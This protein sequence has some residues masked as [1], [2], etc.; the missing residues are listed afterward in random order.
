MHKPLSLAAMPCLALLNDILDISKIEAKRL[1]L[2]HLDF[3]LQNLLDDFISA[4]TLQACEK[5]LALKC[6]VTTEVPLILKGDPSRLRQILANLVSNAIKFT[7]KGEVLVR[8]NVVAES[9]SE[10]TLLFEVRDTGIGIPS[11]KLGLLFAKFSQVDSST[12]RKYGGTGLGLAISKQLAELMGGEIGVQSKP[13]KGSAFWFTVRLGKPTSCELSKMPVA[14]DRSKK[15]AEPRVIELPGC[16][17]GEDARHARI[18]VA[19]DSSIN[20]QVIV[21]ILKK[22][23]LSSDVASNGVEAI[24]ALETT[25][26]D[27]VFMDVQMPEMDGFH[28]TRAIRDPQSLVLNHRVPVIAITAH[29]MKGDRDKCLNAGMDDY[30]TKPIEVP[31]LIAALE[32]WLKPKN[33]TTVPKLKEVEEAV[34]AST[35][36]ELT[37]VFDRASLMRR[38]M[39][40]KEMAQSIIG[41]FLNDIPSEIELLRKHIAA[42]DISIIKHQ[43]HKIKGAFATVG[44]ETLRQIASAMESAGRDGDIDAINNCLVDMQAQ[45]DRFHE[46]M[47]REISDLQIT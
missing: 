2:E 6:V 46:T 28:A 35:L 24:K 11:D 12:T 13:G 47:K 9:L 41:G 30:V 4:M 44:A 27:L 14:E 15:T 43:V 20:Q 40:D 38:V 26:Y 29:A 7:Q 16:T 23:G 37:P 17:L 36:A 19:E 25:P 1:D 33:K 42:G 39:D 32:K 21:R 18:L 22:L 31:A 8:V 10:F 34:Q 3:N 5:G 45:L